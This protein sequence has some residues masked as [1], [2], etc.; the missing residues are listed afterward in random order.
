MYGIYIQ[1]SN[2][3]F[4]VPPIEVSLSES[5]TSQDPQTV[6]GHTDKTET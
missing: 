3:F 6:T 4:P 2:H 1:S 5:Q